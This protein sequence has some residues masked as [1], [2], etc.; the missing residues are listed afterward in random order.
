M[1]TC[2]KHFNYTEN[3]ISIFVV[4]ATTEL[5]ISIIFF[6]VVV[7]QNFR[8]ILMSEISIVIHIVLYFLWLPKNYCTM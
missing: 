8:C 6:D 7:K 1:G 3:I 2:I 4:A 5:I